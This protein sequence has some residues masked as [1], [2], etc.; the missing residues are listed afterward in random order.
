[1]KHLLQN[2]L[3]LLIL[4]SASIFLSGCGSDDRGEYN[5]LAVESKGAVLITAKDTN[6]Q[7]LAGYKVT[8]QVIST[9][10][11]SSSP[12]EILCETTST[13]AI[14]SPGGEFSI[15]ISKVGF[16]PTSLNVTV[17]NGKCGQETKEI[18]VTLKSRT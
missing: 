12:T 15:T 8:Y 4:A 17:L 1:M 14:R 11:T 7:Q 16:E 2:H 10:G 13:C 3:R 5:C 18:D 6:G 9:N